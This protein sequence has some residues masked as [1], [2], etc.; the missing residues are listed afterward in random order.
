VATWANSPEKYMNAVGA[1][2]V[3]GKAINPAW[4]KPGYISKSEMV[5]ENH[6]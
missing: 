5:I 1:M 3:I 2:L 4:P 6:F